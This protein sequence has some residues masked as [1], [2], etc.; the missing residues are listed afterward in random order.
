MGKYSF[1]KEDFT[2]D[3]ITAAKQV[4]KAE[5]TL[6][7]A[8]GN[9]LSLADRCRANIQQYVDA[10][11]PATVKYPNSNI[12]IG[13]DRDKWAAAGRVTAAL[14]NELSA[15]GAKALTAARVAAIM[16]RR[17]ELDGEA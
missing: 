6:A 14:E 3:V 5:E 10:M 1:T 9:Q 12:S 16:R 11:L 15:D 13:S 17:I 4:V 8:V 7:K 2:D